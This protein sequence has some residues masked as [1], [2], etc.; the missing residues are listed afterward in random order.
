M[1]VREIMSNNVVS[2]RHDDSLALAAQTMA[3]MGLR[4]L[5]VIHEGR[6][7]G[8][9]SERDILRHGAATTDHDPMVDPVSSA[10]TQPAHFIDEEDSVTEAA[11][12]MARHKV[13]CLPVLRHGVLAGVI[14]T[15]DLLLL[16]VREAYGEPPER[17][18]SR[19]QRVS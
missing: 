19:A 6:L 10:M 9:L 15:T 16:R 4:H 5:P 13:G 17:V 7:A 14:T 8:V 18:P 2:I 1:L 12:R 3:W 11:E